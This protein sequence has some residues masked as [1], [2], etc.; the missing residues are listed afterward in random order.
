V[1]Q[2]APL[3]GGGAQFEV[4]GFEVESGVGHT[5][6]SAVESMRG[7]RQR[8]E[9]LM[10]RAESN[11]EVFDFCV[12]VEG[13]LDVMVPGEDIARADGERS[14][15]FERRV[16]LESWAYVT[17]GVRGHFGR[18]GAIE[19][20]EAL[21]DEVVEKKVEL[22]AAIDGFAG[23]VGIRD[24]QGA[25]GILSGDL[26][27]RREAFR[28]AVIAAFAPFYN[29]ALFHTARTQAAAKASN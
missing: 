1:Q 25:W 6:L 12:G 3:F 24:R 27:T 16:F 18:S 28:V 20:P 7:A 22:A 23:L 14:A 13:G 15:G 9:G 11:G 21:A 8:A 26:I 17:D 4:M 2:F 10:R 19:L 29:A 5:P